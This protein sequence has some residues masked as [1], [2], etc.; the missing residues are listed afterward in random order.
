MATPHLEHLDEW[1]KERESIV[2][3]VIEGKI[4]AMTIKEAN[5]YDKFPAKDRDALMWQEIVWKQLEDSFIEKEETRRRESHERMVEAHKRRLAERGLPVPKTMKMREVVI[6]RNTIHGKELSE[7]MKK[8][9][10]N[11]NYMLIHFYAFSTSFT[12]TL[13]GRFG[14]KKNTVRTCRI[15]TVYRT[16]VINR[17]YVRGDDRFTIS[18]VEDYSHPK[19]TDYFMLMT[20]ELKDNHYSSEDTFICIRDDIVPIEVEDDQKEMICASEDSDYDT[21]IE[22]PA[23]RHVVTKRVHSRTTEEMLPGLR[24]LG[25]NKYHIELIVSI[26]FLN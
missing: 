20:F 11:K 13:P 7:I 26:E 21:V 1:I 25:W 15:K 23:V 6:F 14:K 18:N 5:V 12:L 24:D 10:E 19:C 9:N 22:L 3:G 4:N 2:Q 8:G 17:V 16:L